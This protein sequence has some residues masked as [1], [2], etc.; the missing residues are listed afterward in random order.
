MKPVLTFALGA[1]LASAIA[2]FLVNRKPAEP[3]VAPIATNAAPA[4]SPVVTEPEPAPVHEAPLAS[5]PKINRG[6]LCATGA[7]AVAA[8]QL[9]VRQ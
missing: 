4:E 1:L 5:A 9:F 2:V 3:A 7:A 6:S 8:D